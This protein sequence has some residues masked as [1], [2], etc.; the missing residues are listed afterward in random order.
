MVTEQSLEV[1][2]SITSLLETFFNDNYAEDYRTDKHI[3]EAVAAVHNVDC[4]IF[5]S[6]AK[7][8][9]DS[10]LVLQE[11]RSRL[12]DTASEIL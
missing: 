8:K 12:L 9:L 4:I 7:P 11:P 3:S 1:C 10:W 6:E 2:S 5:E